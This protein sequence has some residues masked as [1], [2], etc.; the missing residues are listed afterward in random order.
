MKL[1]E[2]ASLMGITKEELI[3]QLKQKDVIELKLIE[4][5]KKEIKDEGSVEV[6]K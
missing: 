2:V 6:L 1:E 5:N 4:K 3:E